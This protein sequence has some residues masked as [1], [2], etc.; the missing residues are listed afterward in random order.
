MK[1][2]ILTIASSLSAASRSSAMA[3]HA[4]SILAKRGDIDAQ[5]MDLADIEIGIYPRSENDPSV[6]LLAEQFERSDGFVLA[7]PVYNW[8]AGANLENFLH[9]ALNPAEGRRY[10]PFV[11]LGGAG[12]AR[13]QLA[14]DGLARTMLAEIHGLQVGPPIIGS[15]ADTDSTTREFSE[16]L[17]SRIAG[18]IDVL[19]E[20]TIAAKSRHN[21]PVGVA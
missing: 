9:Y 7:T 17:K 13:S 10:R 14:L 20:H 6:N 2:V 16:E 12:S 15:A 4:H 3:R 19:A 8:H 1:P 11:I 18:A 21:D 5:F